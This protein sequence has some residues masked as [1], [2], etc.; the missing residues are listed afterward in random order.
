MTRQDKIKLHHE[1]EQYYKPMMQQVYVNN[2]ELSS[3]EIRIEFV[4]W[5][6]NHNKEKILAMLNSKKKSI[7]KQRKLKEAIEQFRAETKT[8][9]ILQEIM[10]G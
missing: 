3:A 2:P 7:K 10:E 1:F 4:S 5:V 8:K 9:D 6:E